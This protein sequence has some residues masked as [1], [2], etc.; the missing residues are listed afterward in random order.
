MPPG[1]AGIAQAQGAM[2]LI[3]AGR[4]R[5]FRTAVSDEDYDYLMQWLWTFAMFALTAA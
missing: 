3:T 4:S 1:A 5:Q 2:R